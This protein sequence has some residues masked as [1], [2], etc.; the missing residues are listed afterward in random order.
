MGTRLASVGV[1][2]HVTFRSRCSNTLQDWFDNNCELQ[3]CKP[4]EAGRVVLWAAWAG[5]QTTARQHAWLNQP[6]EDHEK[7]AKYVSSMHDS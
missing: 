2:Q 6:S 5:F 1:T 3:L 4:P 7:C